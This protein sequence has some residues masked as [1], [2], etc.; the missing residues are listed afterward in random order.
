MLEWLYFE[1]IF[2]VTTGMSKGQTPTSCVRDIVKPT[3][4]VYVGFDVN[5]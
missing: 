5:K 3:W 1:T 4:S 2:Q